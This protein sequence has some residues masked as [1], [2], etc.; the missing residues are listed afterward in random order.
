MQFP[1]YDRF[2][3]NGRKLDTPGEPRSPVYLRIRSPGHVTVSSGT[4]VACDPLLS[5]SDTAGFTTPVPAGRHPVSLCVVEYHKNLKP[6]DERVALARVD[7]RDEPVVRWE[8]ATL[9]GQNVKKLKKDELFGYAVES[10][11]GCFM[12]E[13][14][15]QALGAQLEVDEG[16]EKRMLAALDANYKQTWSWAAL[17]VPGGA[18]AV[19]FTAGDGAGSYPTFFGYDQKKRLTAALTDFLLI[20]YSGG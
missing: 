4:L 5:T 12:D 8:L 20:D 9:A 14:S 10:G 3:E 11:A 1:D 6:Y 2:F 19:L 15:A 13:E 7:F 17:P 18:N 16:L